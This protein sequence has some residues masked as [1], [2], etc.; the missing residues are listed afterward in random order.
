[1]RG[2]RVTSLCTIALAALVVIGSVPSSATVF[3]VDSPNYSRRTTL[4]STSTMDNFELTAA[5][6]KHVQYSVAVHTIGGC[7]DLYFSK[8]HDIAQQVQLI[9]YYV[10]FSMTYCNELY[11]NEFPVEARDGTDFTVT[12]TS[13]YSGDVDYTLTLRIFTPTAAP[14]SRSD[15]AWAC[16][17]L[18]L[19]AILVIVTPV[20]VILRNRSRRARLPPPIMPPPLPPP[21]SD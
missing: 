1:V 16:G 5:T 15:T 11:S 9:V 8:G 17:F 3:T 19:L 20:V 2:I 6:G 18:I 21:P 7:V 12:I 4:N 10:D 14:P 13:T